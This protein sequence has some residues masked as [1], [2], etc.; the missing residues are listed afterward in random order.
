MN[1][2]KD[3]NNAQ[4]NRGVK[5]SQVKESKE[6]YGTPFCP[7]S[8]PLTRHHHSLHV[9]LACDISQILPTRV[10]N[11]SPEMRWFYWFNET[12]NPYREM[13]L[14]MPSP[15]YTDST[16]SAFTVTSSSSSTDFATITLVFRIQGI[17]NC[18]G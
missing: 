1:N 16:V 13:S 10:A 12:V 8:I 3:A 9:F 4:R 6:V 17:R 2:I 11:S 14:M 15:C 7:S 5:M 18:Q